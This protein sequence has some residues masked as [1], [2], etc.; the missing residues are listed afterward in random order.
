MERKCK[1]CGTWNTDNDFCSQCN[2]AISPVELEKIEVQKRQSFSDKLEKSMLDK[3]F[4][5][6]KNSSNPFVRELY[7]ILYGFWVIYMAIISFFLWFIALGP[8]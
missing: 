7:K 4:A 8:G 2:K 5:K 3:S 1:S 6:F